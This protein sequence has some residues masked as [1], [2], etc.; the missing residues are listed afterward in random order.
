MH[1]PAW[2]HRPLERLPLGSETRE[3]TDSFTPVLDV[4]AFAVCEVLDNART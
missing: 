2:R 4:Y 1:V 3:T